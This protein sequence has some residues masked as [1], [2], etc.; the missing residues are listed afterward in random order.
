MA[1]C[2]ASN[3]CTQT[4]HS[5]SLFTLHWTPHLKIQESYLLSLVSTEEL[6][7]CEKMSSVC[8]VLEKDLTHG[9]PEH[10]DCF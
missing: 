5:T 3:Q 6:L 4:S 7:K 9:T 8:T 10:G 2:T 1:H